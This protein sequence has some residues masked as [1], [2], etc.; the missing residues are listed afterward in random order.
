MRVT[1]ENIGSN[2]ALHVFSEGENSISYCLYDYLHMI[3]IL[4]DQ[5]DQ[6][7]YMNRQR[8]MMSNF[9]NNVGA[10]DAIKGYIQVETNIGYGSVMSSAGVK[11]FGPL[12][13]EIAMSKVDK[14]RSDDSVSQSARRIWQVFYTR[15]DIDKEII[16]AD[17]DE[18]D[19]LNYFYSGASV[20]TRVLQNVDAEFVEHLTDKIGM[21]HGLVDKFFKIACV[22]FFYK[23]F[24]K[25]HYLLL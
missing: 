12:M 25:L 14:L 1:S 6:I 21:S 23:L 11:G 3:E 13:Y 24:N 8:I 20:N 7:G 9:I 18:T 15:P 22:E 10:T 4:N 17:E 16:D 5:E 2:Y 19:P